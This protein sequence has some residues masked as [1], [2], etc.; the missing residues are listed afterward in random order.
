MKDEYKG[1][2]WWSAEVTRIP[3]VS[4]WEVQP[5]KKR[6]DDGWKIRHMPLNVGVWK[7]PNL[8]CGD[9]V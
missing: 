6:G 3:P 2:V 9:W 1:R 4:V 8:G 7:V 5:V